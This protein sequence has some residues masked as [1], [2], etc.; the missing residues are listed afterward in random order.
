MV[1]FDST[2]EIKVVGVRNAMKLNREKRV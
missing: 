2:G 1:F